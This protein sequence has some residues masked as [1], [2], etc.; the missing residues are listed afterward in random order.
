MTRLLYMVLLF[1][2]SL[3]YADALTD[4][5]AKLEK[6]TLVSDFTVTMQSEASQPMTYT[7]HIVMRGEEF[8]VNMMDM[9]IAY[10]GSVL[11]NYSEEQNE[12]TLSTPDLEELA[13]ANPLL[14]A[15]TL[16]KNGDYTVTDR[17]DTYRI[18]L[19]PYDKTAGVQSF[20]LTLRKSDLMPLSAVMKE[21]VSRQ[22]VLTL[23]QPAFTSAKPS[24]VISKEGAYLN[25][26]R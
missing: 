26:L 7:G 15:R 3:L 21:T 2:P 13:A 17:G 22:T 25:D 20:T 6:Q 5:F 11:Y 9:E 14:Y 12:L 24:F 4:C 16:V 19:T 10:D 8:R 18:V 23:R 1:F